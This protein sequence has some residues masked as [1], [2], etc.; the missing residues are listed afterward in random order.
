MTSEDKALRDSLMQC[1]KDALDEVNATRD[2]RIPTDTLS[3]LHLYDQRGVFDSLQL[4][5]FMVIFEE[6]IAE[7]VGVVVSVVSEKAFSRKVNPF[8]RVS[9]LVDFV[10]DELAPASAARDC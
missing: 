2:E 4:V 10:V 3:D 1:V 5:N 6:K 8:S 7:R 9:T